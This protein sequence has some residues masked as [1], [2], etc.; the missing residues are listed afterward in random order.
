VTASFIAALLAAAE[1]CDPVP[2]DARR[3]PV[4][5]RAY[6]AVAQEELGRGATRSAALAFREALRVDPTN[7]PARERLDELCRK[8]ATQRAFDDAVALMDRGDRPGAIA[9]FEALRALEPDP[10]AALLE[11]ICRYE[12][13]DDGRA[14]ALLLEAGQSPELSSSAELFLGLIALREGEGAAA[15]RR[16]RSASLG[17]PALRATTSELL[18]RTARDGKLVLAAQLQG[19]YDSNVA[20][21]PSTGGALSGADDASLSVVGSALAR[22]FGGS[23]PYALVSGGYRKQMILSAYDAGAVAAALGWQLEKGESRASADYTFEF[24]AF[25]GSPYL[26]SHVLGLRGQLAMHPFT[27]E[28]AYAVRFQ[29]FLT[30]GTLGY[31]GQLHSGELTL[32]WDPSPRW[33][34]EVGYVVLR[35]VARLAELASVGHGPV[36]GVHLRFT[37][38]LRLLAAAGYRRREFDAVDPDLEVLRRDDVLDATAR[39]ELDLG[40]LISLFVV[41]EARSVSSNVAELSAV[42]VA[43]WLGVALSARVF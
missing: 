22:P 13:G 23:G 12:L 4:A 34:L 10:A 29:S 14:R 7:G 3:D 25:G 43:G 36:L 31:S 19:G 39:L 24:L 9:A 35:D 17:D 20:L 41:L 21:V 37:G 1:L 26:L 28:G 40:R 18:K 8:Q 6:L 42:R 2:A 11:G 33:G 5:A 16:F 30:E 27:M 38:E 32:G 15:E